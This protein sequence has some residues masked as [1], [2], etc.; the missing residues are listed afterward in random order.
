[1]NIETFRTTYEQIL[2]NRFFELQ[3]KLFYDKG[4][5]NP[6]I[7][8][9]VGTEHIPPSILAAFID[10]NFG[11]ND[12]AVF[13]Q[14]RCHSYYLTFNGDPESLALELCGNTKGCNKGM[15]GSASV[16]NNK[17]AN[18]FGHSGLLG[19][20]VPIGT[21]Y[22]FASGKPTVVILGDAAAEEDYVFGALGFAV[23]KN[24]PVL[25]IC[26]DNDLSILTPKKIRRNW[27]IEDVSKGFGITSYSLRDDI[28][29]IYDHVSS[30]LLDPKPMLLNLECQRHLWHAG[31]GV[32]G[33]P[34]WDTFASVQAYAK[35]SLGELE[36]KS[37]IQEQSSFASQIWSTVVDEIKRCN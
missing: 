3:V 8:L 30:F 9:S 31:T 27:R 20:Q 21:G 2:F 16:S 19:D 26:E 5:V 10:S 6:P 24:V 37:I 18:L 12:F 11:F 15:G 35:S 33:Q 13:P 17:T 25:F 7:Y 36:Q 28:Y 4:I 14:H 29:Q 32:D 22:A 23:T 34:K 1:M